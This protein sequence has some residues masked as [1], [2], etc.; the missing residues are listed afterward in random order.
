MFYSDT[1]F[2]HSEDFGCNSWTSSLT[3]TTVSLPINHTK[4][5]V[6]AADTMTKLSAETPQASIRSM[7]PLCICML[8]K[9]LET[10]FV[11]QCDHHT[12][13]VDCFVRSISSVT[14]V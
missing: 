5:T 3:K 13:S 8:R 11:W 2:T 14:T 10:V 1:Y 9:F 6:F 4:D 12:V 7:F